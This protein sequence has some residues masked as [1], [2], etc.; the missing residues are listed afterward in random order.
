MVF[1]ANTNQM[2]HAIGHPGFVVPILKNLVWSLL[3]CMCV[4]AQVSCSD[5]GD[6]IEQDQD[7]EPDNPGE[8]IPSPQFRY[9]DVFPSVRPGYS[10]IVF[11]RKEGTVEYENNIP[12]L[13][14]LNL[15]TLQLQLLV[16]GSIGKPSWLNSNEI[17]Y[18]YLSNSGG[19]RLFRLNVIS[20]ESV[21]VS[22]IALQNPSIHP[23]G[24]LVAHDY[25][26]AIWIL[27]LEMN[28]NTKITIGGFDNPQWSP[29]GQFIAVAETV[30]D[31][32][33]SIISV[34]DPAGVVLNRLTDPKYHQFY[35]Y[36]NWNTSGTEIVF[37]TLYPVSQSNTTYYVGSVNIGSNSWRKITNGKYPVYN[38]VNN[39]IIYTWIADNVNGELRLFYIDKY[40]NN[41]RQ[42]TY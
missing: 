20:G 36:P 39:S 2:K 35:H 21:A 23:N 30:L 32:A 4:L 29:G 26:G 38:D 40:T 5:V 34:L 13:Y 9:A 19:G 31:G 42:L 11:V 28:Q 14:L 8:I 18:P 1:R 3:L 41:I 7:N 33:G 17:Y 6:V 22:E 25:G 24:R 10:E 27:D 16:E 12:G 37:E 15:E